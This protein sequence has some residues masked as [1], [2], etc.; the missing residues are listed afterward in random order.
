VLLVDDHKIVRQGIEAILAEERDIAVVGE[1]GNGREAV[2]LAE[3]LRPD[4]VVMDVAMPVM[5]GDEATQQIKERLPQTR[6]V[7]LSMFDDARVADRMRR[8][9]A[10]AYLLKTAPTEELLAAIRGN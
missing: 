4:V 3:R 10:A 8:A 6:I 9:G 5:A 2:D 1:A 7:A